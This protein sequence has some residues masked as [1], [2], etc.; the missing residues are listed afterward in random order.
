MSKQKIVNE[1]IFCLQK[2]GVYKKN[3]SQTTNDNVIQS[4]LGWT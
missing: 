2:R 3:Y 4:T 1:R